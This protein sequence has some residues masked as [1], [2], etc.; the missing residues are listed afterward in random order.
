MSDTFDATGMRAVD[1]L[2]E[3]AVSAC[4]WESNM[5]RWWRGTYVWRISRARRVSA[6][7]SSTILTLH[8]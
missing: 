7:W 4:V 1:L 2:S 3:K 6:F 8:I 5:Q